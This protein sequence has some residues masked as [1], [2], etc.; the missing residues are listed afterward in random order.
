MSSN[1]IVTHNDLIGNLIT[2]AQDESE[3]EHHHVW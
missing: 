3:K 1:T 2:T